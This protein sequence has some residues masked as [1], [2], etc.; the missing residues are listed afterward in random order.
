MRYTYFPKQEL[1]FT[2]PEKKR[3]THLLLTTIVFSLPL[4]YHVCSPLLQPFPF[5]PSFF[6]AF[7][8]LPQQ[9]AWEIFFMRGPVL[10]YNVSFF[11][12]QCTSVPQNV[13]QT[14]LW[15]ESSRF[16]LVPRSPVFVPCDPSV[17]SFNVPIPCLLDG[18]ATLFKN[19]NSL[20]HFAMLFCASLLGLAAVHYFWSHSLSRTARTFPAPDQTS[21]CLSILLI[22]SSP[23]K[24]RFL[25]FPIIF[26]KYFG[27][28]HKKFR[29]LADEEKQASIQGQWQQES[30]AKE[31]LEQVTCCHDTDCNESMMKMGFIALKNGTWEEY[32]ET[33]KKKDESLRMCLRQDTR[34][35]RVGSTG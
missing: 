32:E 20:Q 30:P 25:H 16:E 29:Q 31:Y 26:E 17:L 35:V 24:C 7:H 10:S 1:K 11:L 5:C 22:I 8:L 21:P 3:S 14:F 15:H 18:D 6:N 2:H 28:V 9:T 23:P 27:F 12:R 13:P 34:G 19:L 33:F 4:F